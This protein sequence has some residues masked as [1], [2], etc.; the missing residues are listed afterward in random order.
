MA[1]A[2]D[3]GLDSVEDLDEEQREAVTDLLLRLAD[4]ELVLAE[5]YT[6]WQVRAPTLESDISLANI[7]QD[8][9]GHA[10]LWYDVVQTFGYDETDLIWERDADDFRHSTLVELPFEEGDW[11]DAVVRNYLYD[12]AEDIQLRALEDSSYAPIRDRVGKVLDEEDYHLEYAESWLEH[13]AADDEG[14]E[15]LQAAL[16][17]LYPYALTLF[18][19][20]DEDVEE[21]IMELGLR[22][23]ELVGMRDEWHDRVSSYLE[24]IGLAVP[25][26]DLP[27]QY[28]IHVSPDDLP[29]HV[30]RDGD[31]TDDW[32][33][34]LDEM[35]ATYEELGRDYATRI[36]DDDE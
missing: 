2:E 24:S 20:S 32:P 18:E 8:E 21:T 1:T 11:A 12:V 26:L 9:L 17:R 27:E 23:E 29:E 15:E 28:D 6:E 5:R 22:D 16:D 14:H 19:P 31:H 7:A 30:G 34:L 3:A 35:T 10:R 25:E 4:D 33:P 13:L 36:M